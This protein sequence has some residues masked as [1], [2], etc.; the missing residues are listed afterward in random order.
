MIHNEYLNST[1]QQEH[2]YVG[3]YIEI[4]PNEF[5]KYVDKFDDPNLPGEMTVTITF[6]Q[7]ILSKRGFHP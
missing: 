3:T 7:V 1:N 2:S 4:K 5:V 6:K